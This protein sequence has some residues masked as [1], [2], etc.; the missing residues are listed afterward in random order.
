MAVI[1][2]QDDLSVDKLAPVISYEDPLYSNDRG[3]NG[4]PKKQDNALGH[5]IVGISLA[6]YACLVLLVAINWA[7]R[8]GD[9]M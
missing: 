8:A 5:A 1:G 6:I 9:D 7:M 3:N 2:I 4:L